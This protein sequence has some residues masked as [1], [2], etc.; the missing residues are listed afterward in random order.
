MYCVP[1]YLCMNLVF[2]RYDV[3]ECRY[4]DIPKEFFEKSKEIVYCPCCQRKDAALK[5]NQHAVSGY[6]YSV[7]KGDFVKFDAKL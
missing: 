4:T 1:L 5:V 2:Y 7:S 6:R 3:D